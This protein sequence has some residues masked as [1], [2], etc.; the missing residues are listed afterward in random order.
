MILIIKTQKI[1]ECRFN[2][3]RKVTKTLWSLIKFVKMYDAT[4]NL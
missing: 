3:I 2:K 1:K 4:S